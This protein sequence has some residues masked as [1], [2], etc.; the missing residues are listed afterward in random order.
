VARMQGS[1]RRFNV[2][3]V[4]REDIGRMGGGGAAEGDED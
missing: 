4:K 1:L 3:K 2:D